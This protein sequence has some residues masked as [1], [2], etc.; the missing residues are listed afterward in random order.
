MLNEIVAIPASG[1]SSFNF[2]NELDAVESLKK[3]DDPNGPAQA[4][5]SRMGEEEAFRKVFE[6]FFAGIIDNA[7]SPD[8]DSAI[9]GESLQSDHLSQMYSREIAE[10]LI[11]EVNFKNLIAVRSFKE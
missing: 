8:E 6:Y 7:L 1:G 2:M 4:N 10:S 11:A 3:I 5:G 9:G